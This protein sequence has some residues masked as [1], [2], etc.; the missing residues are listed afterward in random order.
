MD[1]EKEDSDT[2]AELES[3]I[4]DQKEQ[5]SE[6]QEENEKLRK[7][8]KKQQDMLE[9]LK[10]KNERS[11]ERI[12]K[13]V[14]EDFVEDISVIRE[15]LIKAIQS[16]EDDCQVESGLES[17]VDKIDKM[18]SNKNVR[19]L[20]PQEGNHFNADLHEIVETAEDDEYE[21]NTILN[22]QSPGFM[23]DGTVIKY[24]KVTVSSSETDG[25]TD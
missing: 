24:A 18:L 21:E 14:T 23:Y 2:V 12:E 25:K 15:S 9:E 22:V 3:K 7:T 13:D 17:T 8:V 6:L 16:A 5:L 11:N 10:Y 1:N 19:I 20:Q 4:Q